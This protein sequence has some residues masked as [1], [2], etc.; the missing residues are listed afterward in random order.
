[1]AVTG[2]IGQG[3][4]DHGCRPRGLEQ[5]ES[6]ARRNGVGD[7]QPVPWWLE[8][9]AWI[10]PEQSCLGLGGARRRETCRAAGGRDIIR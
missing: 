10:I 4:A 5:T 7:L 1:M 6:L 3:E 8:R 2:R 9:A